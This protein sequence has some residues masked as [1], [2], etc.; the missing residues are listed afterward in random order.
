MLK[1][2]AKYKV[3]KNINMC[4]YLNLSNYF[5]GMLHFKGIQYI[6]M[7][8]MHSQRC[9]TAS[10]G[11]P[12]SSSFFVFCLQFKLTCWK[13]K[14]ATFFAH[15]VHS[16]KTKICLSL[17]YKQK[18]KKDEPKE[19]KKELCLSSSFRICLSLLSACNS[20]KY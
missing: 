6:V 9:I 4:H 1:H 2:L 8:E 15:T 3:C 13:R 16:K 7:H 19:T 17:K 10:N 12:L 14:K 18:M 20:T 11:K 5:S